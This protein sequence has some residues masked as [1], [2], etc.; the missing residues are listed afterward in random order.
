MSE[1][2]QLKEAPFYQC[3]C[4]CIYLRPVHYHCCTEPKPDPKEYNRCCCGVRKSYACAHPEFGVI[5]DNW[6]KHS[7][8]CECY[9]TAEQKAR[10]D[11]RTNYA[12]DVLFRHEYP[13][14]P[15][16]KREPK[17]LEPPLQR[18]K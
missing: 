2:C 10:D 8:G 6:P 3:C 13:N 16:N 17:K 11:K 14:A 15:I 7:V 9:T 5:H 4:N 1:K 12:L 18:R